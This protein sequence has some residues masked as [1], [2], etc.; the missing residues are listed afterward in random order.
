[1]STLSINK[2]FHIS[3]VN[4]LWRNLTPLPLIL[5]LV[6]WDAFNPEKIKIAKG[7]VERENILKGNEENKIR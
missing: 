6:I 3:N 5:S 4:L 1:M 2:F 7:D